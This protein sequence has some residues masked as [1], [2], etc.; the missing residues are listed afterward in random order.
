[1]LI[2]NQAIENLPRLVIAAGLMLFAGCASPQSGDA[3]YK[4]DDRE[5]LQN[6]SCP[7]DR[8]PVCIQRINQPTRCFCS[9]RDSLERVLDQ[10]QKD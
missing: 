10:Q 6:L 2:E 4:L 3:E 1:M 9:S 5:E 8:T 7:S